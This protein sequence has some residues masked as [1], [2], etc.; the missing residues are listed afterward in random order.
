MLAACQATG[1]VADASF[2]GRV[3][4][5]AIAELKE[6]GFACWLEHRRHVPELDAP[7]PKANA[8][9]PVLFCSQWDPTPGLACIERRYAFEVEW[10]DAKA[11][12]AG[13]TEQLKRRP[14]RAESYKCVS[15]SLPVQTRSP[16]PDEG[17]KGR[18]VADTLAL[19]RADRYACALEYRPGTAKNVIVSCSRWDPSPERACIE[20]RLVFDIE[21]PDP[22]GDPLTQLGEARVVGQTFRCA[23]NW[24]RPA[25]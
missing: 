20:E 6:Q 8:T 24:N 21:W 11:D 3:A 16:Q 1:T 17:F 19:M 2:R 12:D 4:G 5:A 10:A 9:R 18:S 15:P 25:R 23:P 14:I 7:G 13:I 22:A